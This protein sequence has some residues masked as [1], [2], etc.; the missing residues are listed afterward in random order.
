MTV[1]LPSADQVRASILA[2]SLRDFMRAAWPLVEQREFQS[3]WHIDAIAEH[4]EAVSRRD[5]K[6]LIINIPPR[7]MKSLSVGVFWPTWEW[8]TRPFTQFM[9]AS[10]AQRLTTR[11]SLKCR[12]LIESIGG[13]REGGTILERHGYQGLLRLLAQDWQL[14]EDQREKLKFENTDFGYRLATSIGGTG[15]G[16]GGDILVVDDPHK[17]DEAESEV[18]R[19]N[20][21][22]WFDGTLSTRLNDPSTGAV[23]LV[24]QRLHEK[25]ATGHMLTQGGWEHLCLPME[26]EPDHPYRWPDDPRTEPGELLWPQRYPR[27]EVDQLK[28]QLGGYRSAGQ[29]QQRP[30]PAEGFMFKRQDFRYWSTADGR[31]GDRYFVLH[32]DSE[33]VRRFDTGYCPVFQTADIAAS[34]KTT[35]DFTV[36]AT[37]ALTP[38]SDLILLDVDRQ[39]F[40]T[41]QVKQFLARCNV[42][43]NGCPQYVESFGAGRVPLRQ[44]RDDGYAARG[45]K[46]EEGTS[47]DK[48]ARAMTAIARYE[49]HKIFH[50]IHPEFDLAA[51]ETELTTFPNGAHDDQVDAVSYAARLA[52]RLAGKDAKPLGSS[53]RPIAGGVLGERF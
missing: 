18:E 34:D 20:V 26:Y 43:W 48:I 13:R 46:R 11:D 36:V 50:P 40:E 42:K 3:N 53:R 25:D 5:I 19:E 17:A 27:P 39:H 33:T 24:M 8:L 32:D 41:M 45:L 21:L 10:Y 16:E 51:Y 38:E 14:T 12:R 28:T 23:V 4:L 22:D 1:Q 31:I 37:W 52:R 9:F 47:M 44:M 2:D 49:A 6:R 35:A 30:A 29:L 15:T 7:T